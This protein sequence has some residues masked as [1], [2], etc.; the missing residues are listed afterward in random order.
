LTQAA[1]SGVEARRVVLDIPPRLQW[2]AN[3]GYCG[4]ASLIS[5]GLYFGQ[6]VSQYDARALASPGVDQSWKRSQ[7]L[8]GINDQTAAAAMRLK[9]VPW[10]AGA[11]AGSQAFLVWVKDHVT[12]GHPVVI[13]VFENQ[14][15]HYGLKTPNAGDCAYDHIVPVFAVGSAMS[16]T[17]GF[18]DEDTLSFNDL[19][20]WTP[21]GQPSHVFT[22]DFR[23]FQR[24][25]QSANAKDGPPYSISSEPGNA[26][27]LAI[28]GVADGDGDTLP[29][30]VATS[31]HCESPSIKSG[32]TLRPRASTVTLRVRVSGLAPGRTYRVYRYDSFDKV[33]SRRFNAHEADASR[34]WTFN[35]GEA[36]SHVIVETIRSDQMAIY[37][38]VA[39]DAP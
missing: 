23:T 6:Y 22:Y 3:F 24:T 7:L 38:A 13:A 15:L 1:E 36:A 19:G 27:G 9:A 29:V 37:R 39:A 30:R 21:N 32:S 33:P 10:E 16:P 35:G 8:L 12:R 31:A 2:N 28:I 20:G 4:E 18:H 25:R 17:R 11:S 5:A 34:V 14:R 26:Y